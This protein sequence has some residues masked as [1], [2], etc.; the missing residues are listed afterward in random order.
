MVFQASLGEEITHHQGAVVG[1]DKY[2]AKTYSY[3]EVNVIKNVI[4]GQGT[5]DEDNR[6]NSQ[7]IDDTLMLYFPDATPDIKAVDHLTVR[8]ELYEAV[9]DAFLWRDP[10]TG[11]V[12]GSSIRVKRRQG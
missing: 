12:F 5:L 9:G 7:Q 6:G 8:G 4:I 1:K 3:D 11:V 2:N 10:F